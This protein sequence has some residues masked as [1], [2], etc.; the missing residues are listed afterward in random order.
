M[1]TD[2]NA[3][4][5]LEA[6][7]ANLQ[8]E[9]GRLTGSYTPP[10]EPEVQTDFVERGSDRHAAMLQLKK[11]ESFDKPQLDGWALED[12]VSYGPTVSTEYLEQSLRQKVSE[13]SSSFHKMQSTDPLAP[14]FAQTLW[15]PGH[16]LAQIT[17]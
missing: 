17:E 13:L 1:A 2:K 16:R 10:D 5:R 14:N 6:T 4:E 12:I 11:A 8:R 7:V 3:I 9:L 15:R